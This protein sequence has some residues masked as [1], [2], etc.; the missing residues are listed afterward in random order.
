MKETLETLEQS[1]QGLAEDAR[2]SDADSAKKYAEAAKTLAETHTQLM[3]VD[4]KQLELA[5]AQEESKRNF[6]VGMFSAIAK[7]WD[8]PIGQ[9]IAMKMHREDMQSREHML[10]TLTRYSETEVIDKAPVDAMTKLIR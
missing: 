4:I 3:A 8:V 10:E 6:I 1:I 7:Y 5:R 2:N 9:I